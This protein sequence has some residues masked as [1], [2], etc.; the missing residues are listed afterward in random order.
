MGT[1]TMSMMRDLFETEVLPLFEQHRG[2]WLQQARLVALNI[3]ARQGEVTINDV[4]AVIQ[5]PTDVDPRVMGAVFLRRDW[6]LLRHERSTRSVCHNRPVG[7]FRRR[8]PEDVV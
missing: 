5:P 8:S 4:R 7:V 2:D 6:V 3:G 1:E